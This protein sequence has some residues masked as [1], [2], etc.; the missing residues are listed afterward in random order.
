MRGFCRL[1]RGISGGGLGVP[2]RIASRCYYISSL[3][4]CT[5]LVYWNQRIIV[6]SDRHLSSERVESRGCNVFLFE[7]I[8]GCCLPCVVL[9]FIFNLTEIEKACDF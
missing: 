5:D 3:T 9:H 6:F 1:K 7:N 8:G 4:I 2:S